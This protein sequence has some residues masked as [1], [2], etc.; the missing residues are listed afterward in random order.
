[1]LRTII[2][3]IKANVRQFF[4]WYNVDIDYSIYKAMLFETY[5]STFNINFNSV[6]PTRAIS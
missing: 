5:I 4:K 6:E 3:R 1:M 2:S